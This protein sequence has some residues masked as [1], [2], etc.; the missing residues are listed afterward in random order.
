MFADLKGLESGALVDDVLKSVALELAALVELE[1]LE[2][3]TDAGEL[4]EHRVRVV[5][6]V[7][8]EH[9]Q[10]AEVVDARRDD[11]RVDALE[12]EHAQ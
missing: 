7:E 8:Q 1:A 2:M 4:L 10:L 12:A 9:V 6:V 3:S 5:D 11:V